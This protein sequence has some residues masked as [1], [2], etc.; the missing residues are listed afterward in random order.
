MI[1][2]MHSYKT[3]T[4]SSPDSFDARHK[5]TLSGILVTCKI[6]DSVFFRPHRHNEKISD[7]HGHIHQPLFAA[8]VS[9]DLLAAG[10]EVGKG[11]AFQEA[12]GEQGQGRSPA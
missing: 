3:V 11:F 2:T 1:N 6:P 5:K 9:D 4:K 10:D 7:R 8:G 12:V